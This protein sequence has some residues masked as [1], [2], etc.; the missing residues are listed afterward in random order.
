METYPVPVPFSPYE[1]YGY[2][3]IGGFGAV[4]QQRMKLAP[5]FRT[6]GYFTKQKS[7]FA[8]VPMWAWIAGGAV[9]V[10]AAGW[11]FFLREPAAA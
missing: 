3:G 10:G 11:F 6:S 4:S 8:K 7:P 9:V 5:V 1:G 2:P